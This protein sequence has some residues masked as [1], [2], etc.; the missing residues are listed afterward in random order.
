MQS[1]PWQNISIRICSRRA[2][3]ILLTDMAVDL[4][5]LFQI[6]FACQHHH[7]GKLRI[8]AQRLH[9]ADV[10][11]CAEV[12]LLPYT[13]G[14]A[15]HR[16]VRRNHGGN[17]GLM[18]GIHDGAHQ[19]YIIVVDDGIYRKIT[20]HPVLVTRPGYLAQI[21][22]RKGIRRTGTHVQVLDAEIDRVGTCLYGCRKRLA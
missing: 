1:A 22:N 4:R 6:Q 20:F 19:G 9:I 14:I 15:H 16:H 11:L 17:A 3:D 8:E 13:A 5:H 21:I 2:A 18:S 7:I 12:H 10:E